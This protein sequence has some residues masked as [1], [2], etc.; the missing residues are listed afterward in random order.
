[1]RSARSIALL[2]IISIIGASILIMPVCGTTVEAGSSAG[3]SVVN[4]MTTTSARFVASDA[5]VELNYNIR[6][7]D[8]DGTPSQGKVSAFMQ[9]IIQE[10]RANSPDPF[11]TI[12]FRESTSL[13]GYISLFDKEM[14]YRSGIAR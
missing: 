11:G 14:H 6:I 1:M 13:D 7:T 9:G 8:L 4:M 5:P 12:E 10:G 2:V 3:M